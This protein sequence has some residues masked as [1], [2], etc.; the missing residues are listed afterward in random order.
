[1]L[2]LVKPLRLIGNLGPARR[3][4]GVDVICACGLDRAGEL[5]SESAEPQPQLP[6]VLET[7]DK[8]LDSRRRFARLEVDVLKRNSTGWLQLRESERPRK[9]LEPGGVGD[10]R[11]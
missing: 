4:A 3:N 10:R 2:D 7:L 11:R 8:I 6:A 1:M 9:E 5:K